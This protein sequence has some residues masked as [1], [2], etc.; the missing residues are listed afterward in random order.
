MDKNSR[1]CILEPLWDKQR[2]EASSFAIINT[3]PY[4]TTMANGCSKMFKSSD[5]ENYIKKAGLTIETSYDNLGFIFGN[6]CIPSLEIRIGISSEGK[7]RPRILTTR[8]TLYKTP[9]RLT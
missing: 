2:F 7:L 1:L 6:S 5:L 4:F 9:S 8:K 3:S